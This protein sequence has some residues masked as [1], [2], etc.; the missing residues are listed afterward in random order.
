MEQGV[1][2]V[3]IATPFYC[4]DGKGRFLFK[5]LYYAPSYNTT[6]I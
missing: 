1:D 3:G 5:P 4:N 6:K 2:H